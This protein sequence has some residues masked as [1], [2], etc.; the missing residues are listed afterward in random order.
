MHEFSIEECLGFIGFLCVIVAI[1]NMYVLRLSVIWLCLAICAGVIGFYWLIH[2]I[3]S[4]VH[5]LRARRG[6]YSKKQQQILG[7]SD[8]E[9][10]AN[11]RVVDGSL[12][13][14]DLTSEAQETR[15]P[16]TVASRFCATA[17]ASVKK[18]KIKFTIR[19]QEK[20]TKFLNSVA[21]RF[22]AAAIPSIKE[23][24]ITSSNLFV[25]R[26][27]LAATADIRECQASIDS[28]FCAA[29]VASVK[30]EKTRSR[31]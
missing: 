21:S 22:C 11:G 26:W 1:A 12:S 30:E 15:F 2:I 7:L 24:K 16:N 27:Y 20:R 23:E 13:Q 5:V 17:V 4:I 19:W 3:L 6:R 14:Q 8:E 29:A 10:Y 9:Q 31:R 28:R 25:V 18:E